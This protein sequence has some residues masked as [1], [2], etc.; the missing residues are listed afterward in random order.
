MIDLGKLQSIRPPGAEI[1]KAAAQTRIFW[2]RAKRFQYRKLKSI[3]LCKRCTHR[4]YYGTFKYSLRWRAAGAKF[5]QTLS[6]Y[7]RFCYWKTQCIM[8]CKRPNCFLQRCT[9]RAYYGTFKYS[10]RSRAAGAKFWK[11][12]SLQAFLLLW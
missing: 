3:M 11:T 5:W 12:L 1:R 7:K 6:L 9:H 4:A 10:L 8:L 2:K